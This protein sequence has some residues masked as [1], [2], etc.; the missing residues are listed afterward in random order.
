MKILFSGGGKKVG[1]NVEIFEHTYLR[2]CQEPG[3]CIEN[4]RRIKTEQGCQAGGVNLNLKASIG[5]D[6]FFL[7]F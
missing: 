4:P 5:F 2:V 6:S 7:K 1:E 3:N